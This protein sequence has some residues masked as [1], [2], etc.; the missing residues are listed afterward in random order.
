M[1]FNLAYLIFRFTWHKYTAHTR[2]HSARY[3]AR[4]WRKSVACGR[5]HKFAVSAQICEACDQ[6]GG[7]TSQVPMATDQ[8]RRARSV[9]V[10]DRTQLRAEPVCDG[11]LHST[12]FILWIHLQ[13]LKHIFE[14]SCQKEFWGKQVDL[15]CTYFP[16]FYLN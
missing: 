1:L 13:H 3:F 12:G 5:R 15:V 10:Y 9:L 7:F 2:P 11:S 4:K 16:F 6:H 8:T 14:E